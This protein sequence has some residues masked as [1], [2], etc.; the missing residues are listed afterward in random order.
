MFC[1]AYWSRCGKNVCYTRLEEEVPVSLQ[2]TFKCVL[3]YDKCWLVDIQVLRPM[4][5]SSE[6]RD[7][8]VFQAKA[9]AVQARAELARISNGEAVDASDITEMASPTNQQA[10]PPQLPWTSASPQSLCHEHCKPLA[11]ERDEALAVVGVERELA[12]SRDL[13][14]DEVSGT[15]FARAG[16]ANMLMFVLNMSKSFEC[17]GSCLSTP[18][19]QHSLSSTAA[20]WYLHRTPLQAQ[21]ALFGVIAQCSQSLKCRP[22]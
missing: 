6:L 10:P 5:I 22:C 13:H 15:Q 1:A 18:N 14:L 3:S 19:K 21:G 2:H 9:E 11:V 7:R 8:G 4:C 16:V 12:E 17:R 20:G